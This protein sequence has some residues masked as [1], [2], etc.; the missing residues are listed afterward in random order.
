MNSGFIGSHRSFMGVSI[1][2]CVC[3]G[4]TLFVGWNW[5]FEILVR[6]TTL[7]RMAKE[8]EARAST[9]ENTGLSVDGAKSATAP[10][11]KDA[12]PPEAPPSASGG[13]PAALFAKAAEIKELPLQNGSEEVV[14]ALALLNQYWKIDYWKPEAWKERAALVLDSN[15][16][17]DLMKN[18]YE[19]QGGTDPMPGGLL[20]KARYRIN[21]T[22][23][24]YFSYTSSRPSGTLEVAMRRGLQ[25]RF[26][27]DWESLVGYGEM[28]FQELRSKR[29]TKP[30]L[31]RAYAKLFDYYNFEFSDSTKYRCIKLTSEK[32]DHSLFA[33]CE[34]GTDLARRLESE[35]A[36]AGGSGFQGY[37]LRVAFPEN[38]QSNQCVNLTELVTAGWLILP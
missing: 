4:L 34:R 31:L 36:T 3:L 27:I 19:T 9:V 14:Q 20:S 10:A 25:G 24:L 26:L 35:L 12:I 5:Y 1:T 7:I 16:I 29:S 8:A 32:G 17:A 11:P 30:V 13:S 21:G 2:L 6:R 38:A 18:F 33:Y 28:S 15:R 37:T 22:E 23:I